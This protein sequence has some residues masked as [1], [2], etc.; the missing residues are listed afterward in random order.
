MVNVRKICS[1]ELI[2]KLNKVGDRLGDT[3]FMTEALL[4]HQGQTDTVDASE[5]GNGDALNNADVD[6]LE[7][8][9]DTGN[10]DY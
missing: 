9:E 7:D 4:K 3:V 6:A 8:R 2:K 10:N 5:E 1:G